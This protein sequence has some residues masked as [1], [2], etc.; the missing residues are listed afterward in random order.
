[1]FRQGGHFSALSLDYRL[2]CQIEDEKLVI[3]AL[4]IGHRREIYKKY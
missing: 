1:M 3:L 4:P 2:I